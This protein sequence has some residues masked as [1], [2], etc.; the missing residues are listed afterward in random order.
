M[1]VYIL[2]TWEISQS[3][4]VLKRVFFEQNGPESMKDCFVNTSISFLELDE[5]CNIL[6]KYVQRELELSLKER[7]DAYLQKTI[8][9]SP[10]PESLKKDPKDD[11]DFR[12][13]ETAVTSYIRRH[14]RSLTDP[15]CI[16]DS[17]NLMI[18]L[19]AGLVRPRR[20]VTKPGKE[21]VTTSEP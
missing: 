21:N 6:K 2:S 17:K 14:E 12:S 8:R 16:L 20:E 4:T 3:G 7:A 1:I 19:L 9:L 18:N 13:I 11:G 5:N 15:L 10:L